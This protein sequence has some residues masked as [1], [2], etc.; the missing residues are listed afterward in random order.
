MKP[1]IYP[2][3]EKEGFG[4]AGE[5]EVGVGSCGLVNSKV[6]LKYADGGD[7]VSHALHTV[8]NQQIISLCLVT[9]VMDADEVS[10][11]DLR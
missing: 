2:L 5:G 10:K 4:E 6:P 11:G 3:L 1:R 9:K 7:P 8:V